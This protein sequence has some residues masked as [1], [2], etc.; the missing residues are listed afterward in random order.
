M[1]QAEALSDEWSA[2]AP[3]EHENANYVMRLE[4]PGEEWQM[5]ADAGTDA[6]YKNKHNDD[7][8]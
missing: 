2:E 5:A 1:K 4:R 6:H 7:L 8:K 3:E